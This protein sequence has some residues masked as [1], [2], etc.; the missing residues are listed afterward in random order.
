M[1][2]S[3]NAP[4]TRLAGGAIRALDDTSWTSSPLSRPWRAEAHGGVDQFDAEVACIASASL[5][6]CWAA[7]AH[8]NANLRNISR[9]L[10]SLACSA[11][12]REQVEEFRGVHGGK[13]RMM[14]RVHKYR[15]S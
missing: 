2:A 11:F 1:R 6:H 7:A 5:W 4:S 9:S 10:G 15:L 12:L 13:P 8:I 3:R 14:R